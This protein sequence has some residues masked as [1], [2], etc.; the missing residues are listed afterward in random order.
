[1]DSTVLASIVGATGAVI[2]A[3]LS[4]AIARS[5]FW[6][7]LFS[8]RRTKKLAGTR[9]VSVWTDS[10]GE[11]KTIRREI[12]TF[13]GQQKDKVFGFITMDDLPDLKW[14][15]EGD[16]D[17]RFLRLFWHPSPDAKNKF[18]LDC[19]CYF[20]ERR[21]EGSFEG[22]AVGYASETNKIE[23]GEHQLRQIDR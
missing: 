6:D 17:D 11:E 7:R 22:Y 8:R 12:F 4:G 5:D 2:A 19:G 14:T 1:M 9:W 3:I 21:G 20:F 23:A 18:F 16:Y 13:T 15:I 10:A